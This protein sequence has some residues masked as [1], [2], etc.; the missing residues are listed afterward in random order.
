MAA[1][2]YGLDNL[3]L[4]VDRNRLQQGDPTEEAM[5]LEPLL[6]KWRAF[7]WA[8]A[9]VDGHDVS[10]LLNLFHGLPLERGKPSCIVA[11][12]HKGKGVSFM[13][14]RVEWHH[15]VPNEEQLAAALRELEAAQ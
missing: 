6:E 1:A 10:A 13:E 7:G 15:K 8:V 5:R 4:I 14:D 11:H 9:E 12:T 3:T 2:H